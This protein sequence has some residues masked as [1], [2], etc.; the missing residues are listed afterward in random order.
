MSVREFVNRTEMTSL[1]ALARLVLWFVGSLVFTWI[2]ARML[3]VQA[4]WID[5]QAVK[6]GEE[7]TRATQALLSNATEANSIR[8]VGLLIFGGLLGGWTG[9]TLAGIFTHKNQRESSREFLQGQVEIEKAK[10]ERPVVVT[11][12]LAA[13]PVPVS[14]APARARPVP[15]PTRNTPATEPDLYH[16][17][18]S[19]D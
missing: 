10:A 8:Q 11:G 4:P 16:D 19:G 12:E 14:A 2:S 1:S 7:M 13:V 15:G 17:N 6:T 3:T 18:E 9:Q 5:V